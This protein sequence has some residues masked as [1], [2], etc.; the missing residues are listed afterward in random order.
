VNFK[1]YSGNFSVEFAIVGVVFSLLLVFSGDI[2]VK[3]AMKGKLDRMAY[4]AASIIKERTQ[5]FEEDYT[6]TTT[7]AQN[8]YNYVV[9]SLG[10]TLNN[11][12]VNQFG[13]SLDV[14]TNDGTSTSKSTP[15]STGISCTV[16][17]PSSDL[18]VTTSW[19]NIVTLYQ[20]TL[21]YETDNW[22]GDL[23][24]TTFNRVAS[25]SVVMGR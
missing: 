11:F 1:R 23:I 20:V 9:A 6:T 17:T 21:C 16:G 4:S 14:F 18:F 2:I 5:L 25:Y 8:T 7:E 24:G 13:Y 19:G 10:R 3:L 22:Y 15:Y 12:D